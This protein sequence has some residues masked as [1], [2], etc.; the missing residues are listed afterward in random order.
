MLRMNDV[1]MVGELD[2]FGVMKYSDH[3]LKFRQF[4]NPTQECTSQLADVVI[5]ESPILQSMSSFTTRTKFTCQN[6]VGVDMY[7]DAIICGQVSDGTVENGNVLTLNIHPNGNLVDCFGKTFNCELE[8]E[9]ETCS[10]QKRQENPGLP[11]CSYNVPYTRT[12][13]V[14]INSP[15]IVLSFSRS[16]FLGFD[17]YGNPKIGKIQTQVLP[18]LYVSINR[19]VLKRVSATCHSVVNSNGG[20]HKANVFNDDGTFTIL[21]DKNVYL[22]Q[23]FEQ[24]PTFNIQ[25][26]VYSRVPDGF[27]VDGL[28]IVELDEEDWTLSVE[29]A[30]VAAVPDEIVADLVRDEVSAESGVPLVFSF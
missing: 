9:C 1:R 29:V 18:P 13:L 23:T 10:A 11:D 20:H 17:D 21:D 15:H 4:D 28:D 24:H 16:L 30:P 25:L 6:I 2:E 12:Q 8:K 26:L 19:T 3:N 22:N 27:D 14:T 7:G 5:M